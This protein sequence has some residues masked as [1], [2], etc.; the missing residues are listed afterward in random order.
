MTVRKISMWVPVSDEDIVDFGIGTESDQAA[1]AARIDR[2]RE[3][4]D[5]YWRALP[6]HVRI[7]RT[8][9]FPFIPQ[10]Q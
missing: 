10:S 4:L 6:V 7:A 2:E 1:A 5:R 9:R 3:K 8:L